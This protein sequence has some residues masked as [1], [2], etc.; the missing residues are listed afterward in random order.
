MT[1]NAKFLSDRKD[2]IGKREVV[3]ANHHQIEAKGKGDSTVS[4][5]KGKVSDIKV[6][7]VLYVPDITPHKSNCK[8]W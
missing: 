4:L 1:H 2:L 6:T 8:E 7:D 3:L 5:L